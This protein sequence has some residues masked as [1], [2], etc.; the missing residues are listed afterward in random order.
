MMSEQQQV[1]AQQ[2]ERAGE[3]TKKS[4]VYELPSLPVEFPPKDDEESFADEQARKV[5]F[6]IQIKVRIY[7][8]FAFD[9]NDGNVYVVV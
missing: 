1:Q 2:P 9:I 5:T 6:E 7:T 8:L 3:V 4:S